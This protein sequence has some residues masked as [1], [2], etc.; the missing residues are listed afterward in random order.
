[1]QKLKIIF[2]ITGLVLITVAASSQ[3]P[4]LFPQPV[5]NQTDFLMVEGIDERFEGGI[6]GI[7][8]SYNFH[9]DTYERWIAPDSLTLEKIEQL[10]KSADMNDRFYAVRQILS[11][12]NLDT[13]KAVDI[14]IEGIKLESEQPSSLE[15]MRSSCLS[16]S[17]YILR[18]YLFDLND[19]SPSITQL[20]YSYLDTSQGDVKSW[21]VIALGFQK[22][23]T[24]HDELGTI[25]LSDPDPNLRAMAA[26][27]LCQYGDTSDVPLFK[28][29]LLDTHHV[30][31]ESDVF[32]SEDDDGISTVYPVVME[33]VGALV[34]MGYE[35]KYDST[36]KAYRVIEQNK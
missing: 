29:A 13:V 32:I 14:I 19:L 10:V 20:L 5:F 6:A 26:R 31:V 9:P 12:P 30:T 2:L 22:V 4:Y 7:R 3:E 8:M 16:Y 34:K 18:N 33:A 11:V 35:V 25:M 17:E 15:Y 24:V 21:V 28:E 36:I 23:Q 1:M 27:S